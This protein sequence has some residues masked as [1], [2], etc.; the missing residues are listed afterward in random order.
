MSLITRM[1][2][3]NPVLTKELRARMRGARAYWI[4]FGYLGFL[5]AV[6][7]V[8]YAGFS[9]QEHA[10]G[11][12]GSRAAQLGNE[13]EVYILVAQLFLTL[14]ITPA[15][16]SG[17]ITVE[18]EQQTLD[19]LTLT[20]I[21]RARIVAGKLGAAVAFTGLLII[22]SLPLISICFLLGGVDPAELVAAYVGLLCGSV[23][24]GS[25]GLVN[26][27]R[28]KS[29][30]HAV[31]TTYAE[32]VALAIC[33]L[34]L[35]TG[36]STGLTPLTSAVAAV[37]ATWA[38]QSLFG[39]S[40][41]VGL[42][43]DIALLLFAWF[44]AAVAMA[45]L[46]IAP[47][48]RALVVRSVAATVIAVELIT[49]NVAW[50]GVWFGATAGATQVAL[51]SPT[52]SL[53]L[54]ALLALV[55]GPFLAAGPSGGS[56]KNPRRG[57]AYGFTPAGFR[58]GAPS[59]ALPFGLLLVLLM[60][61][62]YA[63]PLVLRG[64]GSLLLHASS[65]SPGSSSG[66]ELPAAALLLFAYTAGCCLLG[67]LLSRKLVNYPTLGQTI[68]AGVMFVAVT[69]GS[70]AESTSSLS[71]N[72]AYLNPVYGMG[73]I[74]SPQ[75]VGGTGLLFRA[76]PPWEVTAAIWAMIGAISLLALIWED[77][78]SAESSRR[79]GDNG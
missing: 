12:G 39:W 27:S 6:L 15:I 76:I 5:A 1:L 52:N 75:S 51:S 50:T 49:I 40:P 16:T 77:R 38:T 48:R 4:L 37:R 73:S 29:T 14:F 7:L 78:R 21:S 3:D 72:L 53:M 62:C 58:E 20:P 2:P 19:M 63:T 69:G 66:G 34:A 46:E 56:P 64:H 35:S 23:A 57:L 42:G 79:V 33:S 55:I 25:L 8:Q 54:L 26:S 70:L 31:S 47:E 24:V 71:A 59:S 9:G 30:T 32:L 41:F 22:S 67:L 43:A 11:V 18:R 36:W 74:C 10:L 68:L 13:I 44:C 61:V 60:L 28:A 45:R 65:S 17:S